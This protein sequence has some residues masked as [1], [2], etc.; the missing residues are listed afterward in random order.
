MHF[1][2]PDCND[3]KENGNSYTGF[4]I[5]VNGIFHCT[6]RYRQLHCLYE[7]IKKDFSLIASQLPPFPSKKILPLSG[8]QLEE[9][10]LQL[11]KYIQA[12]GQEPTLCNS[13]LFNSFLSIAQQETSGLVIEN[14]SI[15]VF[16]MNGYKITLKVLTNERSDHILEKV[17]E[18][19]NLPEEYTYYFALFIIKQEEDGDITV[20]RRLQDFESP[21]LSQQSIKCPN[22]IVLRKSYWDPGYDLELM[23]NKVSLNLLY[24]QT[25]SDIEYGWVL[26]S[27]ETRNTLANFQSRG[28]KKQYLELARTLKYYG[29]LQFRPCICDYPYPGS[30]VLVSAGNKELNLRVKLSDGDD[31]RQGSFKVTRMRCWR[32]TTLHSDDPKNLES[33]N[34]ELSFEYLMAKDKLQWITISSEQAIIMSICLQSMVDELL[35]KKS[36]VRRKTITPMKSNNWN[37]IKRD[38]S[39]QIIT[40]N[41][42]NSSSDIFS[43]VQNAKHSSS[44]N[45]SGQIENSV[46]VDGHNSNSRTVKKLTDKFQ[47]V[48]FTSNTKSLINN[49][50]FDND[51]I[52]DD[53][54]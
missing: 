23:T 1:S 28:A 51:G 3:F 29:F 21:Y 22:K 53:D 30:K 24:I 41:Q 46:V 54:L 34:L 39:S 8:T 5:H 45:N 50:C 13:E 47:S 2:I 15:N 14:T 17:C 26:C 37:Y 38:G 44:S 42:Y 36:G 27:Q 49:E 40:V 35:L 18:K 32:I 19:I 4:N 33:S 10:R 11:E 7:Q 25:I 16:L 48:G 6:V 52:G 43:S 12:V 9:R 31:V 20:I